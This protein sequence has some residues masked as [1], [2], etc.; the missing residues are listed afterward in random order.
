VI[1]SE[2]GGNRPVLILQNDVGN[3]HSPTTIVAV[4]TSR[5][6]KSKLP[7]H[8]WI[9][10]EGQTSGLKCE[11]MVELEQIRTID[12]KRLKKCIGYLDPQEMEAINQKIRISLDV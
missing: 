1:G 8:Y 12:K 3:R 4:I 9:S 5:H 10:D 11:S 6:T 7:T 2:Q